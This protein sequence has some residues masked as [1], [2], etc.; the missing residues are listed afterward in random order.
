MKSPTG[1][2][3]PKFDIFSTLES[4]ALGS[5]LPVDKM[6]R[7]KYIREKFEKNKVHQHIVEITEDLRS[8]IFANISKEP[9]TASNRRNIDFSEINLRVTYV[10]SNLLSAENDGDVFKITPKRFYERSL[11]VQMGGVELLLLLLQPPFMS[12]DARNELPSSINRNSELWNEI[13]VILR[14][15]F[16][17]LPSYCDIVMSNEIILKLFTMLGHTSIQENTMNLLEEVLAGRKATFPLELVSNLHS[18]INNMPPRQLAHFCRILAVILF[19]PEDRMI[20]DSPYTLQGHGILKLRR[21]RLSRSGRLVEINQTLILS[22]PGFLDRILVLLRILNCAPPLHDLVRHDVS[23]QNAITSELYYTLLSHP[24]NPN[25]WDFLHKLIERLDEEELKKKVIN[26]TKH[27]NANTKATTNSP[28]SSSSS[29][30]SSSTSTSTSTDDVSPELVERM[31][32]TFSPIDSPSNSSLEDSVSLISSVLSDINLPGSANNLRTHSLPS[33]LDRA[34]L[35]RS[36]EISHLNPTQLK[37][38]AI[39]KSLMLVQ[40]QVEILFVLCTLLSG[41]RKISVQD[42]LNRLGLPALL[43][44]LHDR[45]SWEGPIFDGPNPMEH[46]HGPDCNCNPESALRVQFLRLVHNFYDRDFIMNHTKKS[47]LSEE[48]T[49][50]LQKIDIQMLNNT[51]SNRSDTLSSKGQYIAPENRGLMCSIMR[52]LQHEEPNSSYR[53]WLSSCLEAFLRG[54]PENIK[55]FACRQGLLSTVVSNILSSGTGIRAASNLQSAFDLLGELLKFSMHNVHCL[56]SLLGEDDFRLFIDVILKNLVDS[57]VF[58]RSLVVTLHRLHNGDL[59]KQRRFLNDHDFD[60]QIYETSGFKPHTN[61][62]SSNR[63]GNYFNSTTAAVATTTTATKSD[64]ND[65]SYTSSSSS[66]SV[67]QPYYL[68]HSWHIHRPAARLQA[69]GEGGSVEDLRSGKGIYKPPTARWKSLRGKRN[70][71]KNNSV[72]NMSDMFPRAADA[73]TEGGA[74]SSNSSSHVQSVC[75]QLGD[76]ILIQNRAR[77][78]PPAIE[79]EVNDDIIVEPQSLPHSH[80]NDDTENTENTESTESTENTTTSTSS[81]ITTVTTSNN[82]IE[83]PEEFL[84]IP[85]RLSL[86]LE[87]SKQAILLK[88]MSS[89]PVHAVNHE[90][91]CCLNTALL[92]CVI[93][94]MDGK[95]VE[96]LA[97]TRE[98][99]G[100]Q[101]MCGL[102]ESSPSSSANINGSSKLDPVQGSVNVNG[103]YSPGY[104]IGLGLGALTV[105]DLTSLSKPNL[106]PNLDGNV[107]HT[108]QKSISNNNS[109]SHTSNIDKTPPEFTNFRKLL[110]FWR[111]YYLRRGRDRLSLEFSS[112]ISFKFWKEVVDILCADDGSP[113]ALCRERVIL[114]NSPYES[115][116]SYA[117]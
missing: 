71:G 41:R 107:I 13:L 29:S 34:P 81:N 62:S 27:T 105:N 52:T 35:P 79:K 54:S 46:T 50:V 3:G 69:C 43:L 85:L 36:L 18:L 106:N 24:R 111:E 58:L 15:V 17:A 39:L 16:Y 86:F 109:A 12:K 9:N 89:V 66:P 51:N 103:S 101:L 83:T 19:E 47:L 49:R 80:T 1:Y 100:R 68:I 21:N 55:V 78:P 90:N 113:T 64:T 114:P 93:A 67:L 104:S 116:P 92:F 63:D 73:N 5:K 26:E 22:M 70:N 48:E 102:C 53:F 82:V 61:F 2:G 37:Y 14:E 95:L 115:A 96:L 42:H 75:T 8:T 87:T 38:I 57:N 74:S 97:T 45:M 40:H 72:S 33:Y 94:H 108:P 110:W 60:S 117:L 30:S 91:I 99:A 76:M 88:L 32:A 23:S 10:I 11:F 31:L 77:L 6:Y 112:R 7:H 59:N 56:E 25:E 20:M 84:K 4:R 98:H 65:P 44:K 28:S